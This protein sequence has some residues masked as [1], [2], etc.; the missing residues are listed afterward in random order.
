MIILYI[1]ISYH[2]FCTPDCFLF[3]KVLILH[4]LPYCRTTAKIKRHNLA[5]KVLQRIRVLYN[6]RGYYNV[7]WPVVLTVRTLH[8]VLWQ[9]LSKATLHTHTKVQ[10]NVSVGKQQKIN[11][12][13]RSSW[14]A[15][16]W[17]ATPHLIKSLFTMADNHL[18]H[19]F[20]FR[21]PPLKDSQRKKRQTVGCHSNSLRFSIIDCHTSVNQLGNQ[22]DYK[23][24][25]DLTRNERSFNR[26]V[27]SHL[28][29]E[30]HTVIRC[31]WRGNSQFYVLLLVLDKYH[32][33]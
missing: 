28:T 19:R 23:C 5:V 4:L 17:A 9:I 29:S 13:L 20:I 31:G 3:S 22:H 6:M 32:I 27:K 25:Q 16:T 14:I 15:T 26:C 21:Q 8:V 30:H 18:W 11:Y 2:L 24:R 7:C 10:T 1:R 12:W 33:N